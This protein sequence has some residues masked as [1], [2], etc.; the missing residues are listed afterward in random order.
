MEKKFNYL[1]ESLK[2][3]LERISAK[4]PA[5]GGGSA[6]AYIACLSASLVNMVLSFTLGREKYAVCQKELETVKG[7]T[8]GM[9][10]KLARYVEEDSEVYS[11]VRK[12][13]SEEK[14]PALEEKYLKQSVEMQLDICEISQ[15]I[16]NFSGI[17]TEKANKGLISDTGMA[18]ALAVAAFKSAKLNVLINL[19]YIS[20][21]EFVNAGIDRIN[22]IEDSVLSEGE[23]VYKKAVGIINP[24]SEDGKS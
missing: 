18:A 20:E 17:L 15:K 16:I 2:S 19:K 6:A 22:A 7:E 21:R 12:Y 4:T 5:P 8:C 14:N 3:Y 11:L 23:A 10:E 24:R 9:L 13:S 1:D